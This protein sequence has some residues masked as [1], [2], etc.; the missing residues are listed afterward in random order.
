MKVA[1]EKVGDGGGEIGV[2]V[3]GGDVWV[4]VRARSSM[5]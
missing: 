4:I 5:E 3:T 1:V 2:V